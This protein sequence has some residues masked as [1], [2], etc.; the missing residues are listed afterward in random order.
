MCYYL[1]SIILVQPF[2]ILYPY[3]YYPPQLVPWIRNVPVDI[4]HFPEP[5]MALKLTLFRIHLLASG[6]HQFTLS[7]F[8]H[9]IS[10]CETFTIFFIGQWRSCIIFDLA[11][12]GGFNSLIQTIFEFY[13]H[14]LFSG[15]GSRFE[16]GT[17]I[18]K[19]ANF[20][21]IFFSGPFWEFRRES[22]EMS[23]LLVGIE[24]VSFVARQLFREV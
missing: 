24:C 12:D 21:S 5:F 14:M 17:M 6:H 22:S 11:R 7:R 16:C 10:K 23:F 4:S 9:Y 20:N 1:F 8:L 18:W 3:L 15:N 19:Q 2:Y 13:G